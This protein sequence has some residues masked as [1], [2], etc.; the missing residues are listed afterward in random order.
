MSEADPTK[1]WKDYYDAGLGPELPL[2]IEKR[3]QPESGVLP[4]GESNF[5]DTEQQG[6]A[7]NS[8]WPYPNKNTPTNKAYP[9]GTQAQDQSQPDKFNYDWWVESGV[10]NTYPPSGESSL[11]DD[12][13]QSGVFHF[14]ESVS[15]FSNGQQVKSKQIED[16]QIFG[17]YVHHERIPYDV[18]QPSN[19]GTGNWGGDAIL[20][21]YIST[22]RTA[23]DFNAYGGTTGF[24]G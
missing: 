18:T 12:E 11:V 17:K 7:I 9:E 21:P 23:I 2:P 15:Q 8:E 16:F 13:R 5:L 6:K 4:S 24:G 19:P 1:T 10:V 3:T 20:I 14:N 22:Y